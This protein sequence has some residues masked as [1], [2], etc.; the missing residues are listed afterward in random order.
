MMFTLLERSETWND[1]LNWKLSKT[2]WNNEM[3]EEWFGSSLFL[4]KQ[5]SVTI[6]R[7]ENNKLSSLFC[8]NLLFEKSYQNRFASLLDGLDRN[9]P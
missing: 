9:D 4:P 1:L 3:L 6:Y 2:V 5:V 7:W 8:E